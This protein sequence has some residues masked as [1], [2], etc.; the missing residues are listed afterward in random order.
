M[1]QS[2]LLMLSNLLHLHNYLDPTTSPS[3]PPPLSPPPPPMPPPLPRPPSFSLP[4]L[5]PLLPRLA[6]PKQKTPKS[7][8]PPP[9]PPPQNPLQNSPLPPSALFPPS[10]F[11]LWKPPC[12]TRNGDLSTACPTQFSPLLLKNLNPI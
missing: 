9:P 6:S 10:T 7:S 5:R 1:D 12:A 4:L 3:F 11:G 8:S 2:F